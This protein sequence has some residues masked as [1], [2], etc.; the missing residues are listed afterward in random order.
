MNLLSG[1][2][3]E[4]I[5][6]KMVQKHIDERDLLNASQF[7]FRVRHSKTLQCM[8][9]TDHAKLNFNNNILSFM[10]ATDTTR[11]CGLLYM[12]A[13]LEFS[14]SLMKLISSFLPYANSVLGRKAKCLRQGKCGQGCLNVPSCPLLCTTYI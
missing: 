10:A 11:H 14:S 8:R 5:I 13:K 4:K 9:L 2:L 7:G 1:K 3:F 6:L 12:I